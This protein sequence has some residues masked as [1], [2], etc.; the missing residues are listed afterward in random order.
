MK[1]LRRLANVVMTMILIVVL[2]YSIRAAVT[3]QI[4]HE[5]QTT[6]I[7]GAILMTAII[8]GGAFLKFRRKRDPEPELINDPNAVIQIGLPG[9][10][11]VVFATMML[12]AAIG[13]TIMIFGGGLDSVDQMWAWAGVLLFGGLTV[14]LALRRQQI[15]LRLSPEGIDY[16]VFRTGPIA[17]RDIQAATISTTGKLK[18]VALDVRNPQKY[19]ARR[20][21][22]FWS[23]L[24]QK[25]FTFSPP[26]SGVSPESIVKA[27]EVR[28]STFGRSGSGR[29]TLE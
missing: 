13:C 3:G 7:G 1:L 15:S 5:K 17:W 23:F 14:F 18:Q 6:M 12:F 26:S 11:T 8:L 10:E 27:I 24:E 29:V 20:S 22:S 21:R 2:V 25:P 28:L 16:T 9:I 4:P 19:L